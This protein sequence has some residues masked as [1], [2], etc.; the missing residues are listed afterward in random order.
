MTADHLGAQYNLL[1]MLFE[2]MPMGLAILDREYRILRYNPTWED[3]SARYAPPGGAP[4]A[5]GVGYFEHIPGAETT[6]L[7]LYERVLAGETIQQNDVRLAAGGI[8]SY[9]DV[10]LA[11]LVENEQIMGILNVSID[12]TERAKLRSG[13]EQ[14]VA[15]RTQE[16]ERRRQVAESMREIVATINASRSL[17]ETLSFISARANQMLKSQACLVHH[18]ENEKDFVSIQASHGL[19]PELKVIP[20]FPLYSSPKSDQQ[21]LNREPVWIAD[22]QKNTP[23]TDSQLAEIHPDVRIWREL[24]H[25]HY[26]AWL[27]VP[28]V[29][30]G[31]I[32]GS[33]AFYFAEPREF[34]TEEI[35]LSQRY[36]DQAALAIEN[37]RLYEA[38]QARQRELQI[39]LDVASAANSSLDLDEILSQTLDLIVML[40]GASRAGTILVDENTGK[41]TPHVLRPEHIVEPD[42]MEKML[43]A[44]QAV[45]A[46]GEMMY[47]AADPAQ[48][49]LEPGALLP[50]MIRGKILGVLGIIGPQGGAFTPR[51]LTLFKSIAEQLGIA[52]E[53]A[54]LYEAAEES[55]VTAERNRLA[56]DL[57]DAVTQTLFSASMIADVLPKIWDR[58]PEEG[59][60]R[61][62]ELRQLTRG[63]LSEM[64]TLL[65]ELRPAA[66]VDT[67]LGDLLGHQVNAFKARARL[68][69]DFE[70]NCEYNP[71]P[72]IK[73]TVYRVAQEAFNNIAKHAEAAHVA[74]IL[75][76]RADSVQLTIRDDGSGFDVA[77]AA[78]E[79]LGLGIMAE[80]AQNVGAQLEIHSQIGVGTQLRVIWQAKINREN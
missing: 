77:A 65:V 24:T 14:R 36:A 79:G 70:C 17:T 41:L 52:I 58:H 4:L 76:T 1:E 3:F 13:L 9:W 64:R 29:V 80:R 44:G 32:Y 50:I 38:E 49:L 30:A 22:F 28:L 2:R 26:R 68:T 74:V 66:L 5:P 8:V 78:S 34:D 35:N 31:Q 46:S 56:R 62:E 15:A 27:A 20:G 37:T 18:I 25:N 72:E 48:G 7:P 60:R 67:D 21:I 11:P 42:D 63:A 43:Q 33:L 54:R 75:K 45:I 71:P 39:L 73:E 6:V 23:L 61:L 51:Q 47:V 57:H 55:A 16:A 69:V 40:V 19:P 12:T 53:N 59:Q 10:V